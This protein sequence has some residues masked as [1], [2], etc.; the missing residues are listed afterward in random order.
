MLDPVDNGSTG[1]NQQA[2]HQLGQ[3]DQRNRP[4]IAS[5]VLAFSSF[6]FFFLFYGFQVATT[7]WIEISLTSL[8]S[9]VLTSALVQ[10]ALVQTRFRLFLNTERYRK[11]SHTVCSPI[12]SDAKP[13]SPLRIDS[14]SLKPYTKK[15]LVLVRKAP[16]ITRFPQL[17]YCTKLY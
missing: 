9:W 1:N 2:L 10:N 11:K 4:K 14:L 6:F 3:L 7:G 5:E 16:D 17:P 13:V 15:A 12:Y 8:F